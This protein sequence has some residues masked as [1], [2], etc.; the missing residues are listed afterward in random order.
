M[1]SRPQESE[2]ESKYESKISSWASGCVIIITQRSTAALLGAASLLKRTLK[3]V[4]IHNA[5]FPILCA[6][7]RIERDREGKRKIEK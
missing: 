5:I 2:L 3:Y 1:F 4:Y 7:K 6:E